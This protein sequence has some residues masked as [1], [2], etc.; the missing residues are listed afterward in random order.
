MAEMTGPCKRKEFLDKHS[1][2][3]EK[4]KSEAASTLELLLL[5]SARTTHSC[6][7]LVTWI[8]KERTRLGHFASYM[9]P[10]L[11]AIF[12]LLRDRRRCR[13]KSLSI[14]AHSLVSVPI[15]FSRLHRSIIVVRSLSLIFNRRHLS[16]N[17]RQAD[18]PTQ[19]EVSSTEDLHKPQL[20]ISN[21]SRA[22]LR[23]A[24]IG[25]LGCMTI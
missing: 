17:S 22:E 3:K 24:E 20:G 4:K 19:L 1:S 9:W 5:I 25:E 16:N 23:R 13:D 21:G 15:L 2:N 10:I 8:R 6:N 11:H 7:V 12:P 18:S 14:I